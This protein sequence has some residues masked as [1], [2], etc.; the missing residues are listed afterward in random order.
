MPPGRD[1]EAVAYAY[2][3]IYKA[4]QY[5]TCL[6]FKS[7]N[8]EGQLFRI[9]EG[10]EDSPHFVGVSLLNKNQIIIENGENIIAKSSAKD[11]VQIDLSDFRTEF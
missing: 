3:D 1:P 11:D 8:G 2:L 4:V 10:N 7:F 5:Q 9:N 6:W